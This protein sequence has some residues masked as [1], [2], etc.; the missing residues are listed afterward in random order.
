[1]ELTM[2][3]CR[4]VLF[5][6]SVLALLGLAGCS[7]PGPGPGP[8]HD[9]GS[10]T[11]TGGGPIIRCSRVD[12]PDMDNISSMDESVG[13]SDGDGAPNPD[14]D[15]DG[16]PNT[17]DPD[18][19]GDG[20]PD[21]TEAGD[22]DCTTPPRD[23]DG[24]HIPDY[25]DTDANADG[26]P[27]S[28]EAT[29]DLDSDG[30]VDAL[31]TDVDGD[32]ISNTLE[33]GPPGPS[34]TDTDGDGDP[35]VIDLDSDGDTILDAQEGGLDIDE[36]GV[37]NFRD[38]DSD[39]DGI[40]D[41]VEAGDGAVG[42]PPIQCPDEVDPVTGMVGPDGLAD[43]FDFDSDNDGL[44]DRDELVVGTDPCNVDTDGDG[45]GDLAEGAYVLA[46]CPDGMTGTD[47]NCASSSS[48]SIPPEH[49]FV[50]LPYHTPPIDRDLEF[51]TSIRVADVFFITD[52][53]GSMG[54]TI[55]HVQTTVTTPVTG[56]IDRIAETIPDAWVGGGGHSD[57]PFGG[58]D[59]PPFSPFTLAIRMTPPD[60]A[61]EVRTA[62]AGL[63]AG[64]GGDGP[65]AQVFAIHEIVTGRGGTWMGSGPTFT[66]RAYEG[67]CLDVG[68]GAPC[69]REAALPII[70]L[71]TDICSHNGPAGDCDDY[72]GITPTPP[73]FAEA[74]A[75]MNVR[76]A[77]FIGINASGGE[78]CA[79]VTGPSG[80]SPCWMEKQMA[81]ETGSVDLDGNELVY[82]LPN[83]G[84]SDA[85]FTDTIVTAIETIATRVPL[86][87]TTRLRDDTSDPQMVDARQFIFSRRPAC[88]AG[89]DPCWTE[90]PEAGI[91]HDEAVAT[92]DESTFF[93]V[94]PG[95]RVL[96]RIQFRN[97]F[98][99]GGRNTE[100]YKAFI[101]VT[102]GGSAV[103]D[104]RQVYI[105]IPANPVP[106][107]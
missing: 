32:G 87:I 52:T 56:I 15:G 92:Y 59:S 76:G 20:V 16:I 80:Y 36:D 46:N 101:D 29:S 49:F 7:D 9:G 3:L 86:D 11:D 26:I 33:Y 62:F 78:P 39:G 21:L 93:G 90:N 14:A 88:R 12:D 64:G 97:D 44:G 34:P 10:T 107:G 103:L 72:V 60:R 48:C 23:L 27:D 50:V 1:M 106:F 65:E 98:Y 81:Q 94:I 4:R 47:C 53:T 71:F 51:G 82:D 8:G 83:F 61:A 19:D 55:G 31:D 73:T 89:V 22:A 70:V 69:F 58:Y 105:V 77:R 75:A 6:A 35:D 40:E 63:S 24:D 96:F 67:D 13:D 102:A 68:W 5:F 41:G 99:P 100:L 91:T 42:T 85:E 54:G 74:V 43:A 104:T 18:S 30:I 37:E 84:V 38:L 45:T 25:L 66:L 79:T 17:M 57:M 95:T 2:A 28:T